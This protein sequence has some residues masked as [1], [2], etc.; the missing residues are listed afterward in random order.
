MSKTFNGEQDA[1]LAYLCKEP[2]LDFLMP[3][4]QTDHR[5][6]P[7]P[8]H[9]LRAA[10]IHMSSMTHWHVCVQ[11]GQPCSLHQQASH[12]SKASTSCSYIDERAYRTIP[13]NTLSQARSPCMVMFD[14]YALAGHLLPLT[15]AQAHHI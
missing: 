11:S 8:C 7:K 12:K 14:T 4:E 9:K 3:F 13:C 10:T 15:P 6:S 2:S 1:I 5:C